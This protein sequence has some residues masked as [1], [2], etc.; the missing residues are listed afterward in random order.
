MPENQD[1]V[2]ICP[3]FFD[4]NDLIERQLK[5][6]FS[7]VHSFPDMPKCS[8]I[9]KALIKYN[10]VNYNSF[11][12][13]K[14]SE[15]LFNKLLVIIDK[16]ST[17]V[18]V[19]GTCLDSRF[20]QNIKAL[21]PN[22]RIVVYSWDSIVNSRGF[23]KL[24]ELADKSMS[25]DYADCKKYQFEYLPLFYPDSNDCDD[26]ISIEHKMY[27]YSF[28]GSYHGDRL[29]LLY[30]LLKGNQSNIKPS[31]IRIYFQS[32]MQ[33]CV[34]YFIDPYIRKCPKEWISFDI[35]TRSVMNDI[36][37]KSEFI[38]DIHHKAQSGLTMRTW[39]TLSLNYKL[40]TT[41]SFVLLHQPIA[42]IDI[43]DR[44]NGNVWNDDAKKQFIAHY[45]IDNISTESLS[46]SH[47]L[48]ELLK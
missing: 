26:V 29:K 19:K 15:T 43:L 18:I 10:I 34:Y 24:S 20:I 25:F 36:F 37:A 47:W 46:L 4:Y 9:G 23:L 21:K 7:F 45:S 13:R 39:E 38:I 40:L 28:I 33:F 44:S 5:L 3:A 30:G 1:A 17:I 16:I 27:N 22:I 6:R 11:V 35:I 8:S 48:D 2:L 31:F 12:S 32:R 42:S 41:N 14:Y